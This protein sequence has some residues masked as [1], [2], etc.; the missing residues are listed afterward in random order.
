MRQT[1]RTTIGIIALV[2]VLTPLLSTPGMISPSGL[3][4]IDT[5]IQSSSG[6]G[7][8]V[9]TKLDFA[10]PEQMKNFPQKIGEWHSTS[11]DWSGVKQTLGADLVLSRAY[12]SPNYSSPVF[13]VIVQGSNLSS[14]H[15]PVVCYPALGYEIEEEGKV[16]IPVANAS[17]AKGPW[18]SEKEGLLFRGELSAKKLVVVKRGEDG[19]ITE[20]RVVLYYFV[21]DER[22]SLP[23]EV[24]MV[25][26]SAL[27]P[28]SLSGSPQAVLEPVKKLAADSFPEMFEVKPKEKMVAE[29]LVSEHGVLGSAV[30][31]VLV[32]APVGYIIFPFVRRRRKEGEVE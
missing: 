10:D 2:C 6:T 11:Y 14:F 13:F 26:V 21:K 28:L 3:S 12:R 16:K 8:F 29:M 5:Q 30:I 32:L 18:R 4:L 17:W 23:K 27:A 9:K 31:A 24:T 7:I 19:E 1:F 20:R 25:R 22:M 15:P